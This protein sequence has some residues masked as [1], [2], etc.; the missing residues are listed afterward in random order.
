M[1]QNI[2]SPRTKMLLEPVEVPHPWTA[3]RVQ[4]PAFPLKESFRAEIRLFV[5][6]LIR[7]ISQTR[8]LQPTLWLDTAE[9]HR[10]G[11]PRLFSGNA[12]KWSPTMG[13]GFDP[14]GPAPR[15][16]EFSDLMDA[17]W[18]TPP[19]IFDRSAIL[20]SNFQETSAAYQTMG[21]RGIASILFFGAEVA[22][23]PTAVGRF[24]INSRAT[25]EPLVAS[26]AFKHH[27]FYLPLLSSSSLSTAK[28]EGLQ[29]WLGEAEIYLREVFEGNELL[30]LGKNFV[31]V[32]D[33]LK[34][35]RS[36][37][38]NDEVC[39]WTMIFDSLE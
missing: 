8:R 9:L 34:M 5:R 36:S 20:V 39:A 12:R 26:N 4:L 7:A 24:I 25:L 21:G 38:P 13:F 6:H 35:Q 28:P 17:P 31:P 23:L 11:G 1:I 33:Q 14:T 16:L 18:G 15:T 37:A 22:E 27:N 19:K 10:D 3:F 30:L 32:F 29:A 2:I